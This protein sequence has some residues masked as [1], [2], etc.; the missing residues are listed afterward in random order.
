MDED[1]LQDLKQFITATVTQQISQQ[2]NEL[3][4]K[5]LSVENKIDALTAFV[6]EAIDTSNETNGK[7]LQEHEKRITKLE[8]TAAR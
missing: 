1:T 5:I 6:T 4:E 8:Q 3:S 2:T 7:Q